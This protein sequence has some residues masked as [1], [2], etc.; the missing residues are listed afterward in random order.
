[1]GGGDISNARSAMAGDDN[2]RQHVRNKLSEITAT[3]SKGFDALDD[4]MS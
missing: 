4:F 2:A 3:A 1:M